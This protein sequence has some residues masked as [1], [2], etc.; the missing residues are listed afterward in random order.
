MR[1]SP[2]ASFTSSFHPVGTC[3]CALQAELSRGAHIGPI[4]IRFLQ[5]RQYI[6]MRERNALPLLGK[7]GSIDQLHSGCDLQAAGTAHDDQRASRQLWQGRPASARRSHH[8]LRI[9][10][11]RRIRADH[12][13]RAFGDCRHARL[14]GYIAL[15]DLEP[16]AVIFSGLRTT[17][18]TWCPRRSSSC[19]TRVPIIPDAPKRTTFIFVSPGDEMIG[20][21]E[22]TR[23]CAT[24]QQRAPRS[25]I[26]SRGTG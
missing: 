21:R 14:V 17:A 8:G 18:V 25:T 5:D 24:R 4:E 15:H 9:V 1:L 13:I 3:R 26:D 6:A 16:G 7:V 12:R 22:R 23:M 19:R 11:R 10:L 2:L 20:R